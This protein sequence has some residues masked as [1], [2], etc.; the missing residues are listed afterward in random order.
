MRAGFG[1]ASNAKQGVLTLVSV[2]LLALALTVAFISTDYPGPHFGR[3]KNNANELIALGVFTAVVLIWPTARRFHPLRAQRSWSVA[4]LLGS[5]CMALCLSIFKL[6]NRELGGWD[7]GITID[8]GWRQMLGQVPYLDFITPNPP[9]FNLGSYYAFRLFG[10]SWNAHLYLLMIFGCGTLLWHFWLF[11]ELRCSVPAALL[12]SVCIQSS[13]IVLLSFW[14]YNNIVV[15]L[16]A[17]F[18][19]T[20]LILVRNGESRRVWISYVACLSVLPLCK[21]NIAGLA[22]VFVPIICL[23]LVQQRRTFLLATASGAL[24]SGALVFISGTPVAAMLQSY[25][26]VAI[27]RGGLSR[28]G[29]LI[30]GPKRLFL[31]ELWMLLLSVPLIVALVSALYRK[32]GSGRNLWAAICVGL[33]ACIISVYGVRT[34]GE[35]KPNEWV[36]LI[37]LNCALAFGVFGSRE[38]LHK[39]YV[40]LTCAL[41][42]SNLTTAIRRDRVLVIGDFYSVEAGRPLQK[43]P[44]PFFGSMR[45]SPFSAAFLRDL[46]ALKIGNRRVLFGPRLEFSYA[47]KRLRSPDHLPVYWQPGTSFARSDEERL[48]AVWRSEDFDTLVFLKGGPW[49]FSYPWYSDRLLAWIRSHYVADNSRETITVWTKKTT[50]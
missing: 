44:S 5:V 35:L 39:F 17:S 16:A 24:L 2:S 33:A 46:Q 29:L 3:I 30:Y 4:A 49:M 26:D 19:L 14:W 43:L 50:P 34:D 15:V 28:F 41:I 13:S 11:R 47:V 8:T 23:C 40:A 1:L 37:G 7:Y 21:P 32:R 12:S 42:A 10:V 36:P 31:I 6:G 9:L 22:I 18:L 27:E 38:T 48:E 20:G 25:R 45:G